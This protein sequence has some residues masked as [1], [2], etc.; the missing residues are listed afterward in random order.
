MMSFPSN[1]LPITIQSQDTEE[2]SCTM[3]NV[4]FT[5]D[6]GPWEQDELA[7]CLKFNWWEGVLISFYGGQAQERVEVQLRP[8]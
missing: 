4:K 2:E 7:E 1:L 5:E 6:F 3:W 8:K